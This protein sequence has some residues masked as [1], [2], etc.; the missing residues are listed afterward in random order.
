VHRGDNADEEIEA[1]AIA[2]LQ[3][4]A[5]CFRP[6]ARDAHVSLRIVDELKVHVV[7]ELAVDADR[8]QLVKDSF[9]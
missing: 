6:D 8:L 2:M 7:R 3:A 9:T 5:D 1:D 4:G